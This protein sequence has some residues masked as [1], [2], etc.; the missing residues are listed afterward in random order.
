MHADDSYYHSTSPLECG[1]YSEKC[2]TFYFVSQIANHSNKSPRRI[3]YRYAELSYKN[4]TFSS[5]Q[6]L[7]QVHC[8]W[9]RMAEMINK[10]TVKTINIYHSYIKFKQKALLWWGGSTWIQNQ[11]ILRP[12]NTICLCPEVNLFCYI[13]QHYTTLP[14]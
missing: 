12:Q 3:I 6:M 9:V 8:I 4:Q 7:G 1:S 2:Q 11:F 14:V 5:P 13:S 10:I